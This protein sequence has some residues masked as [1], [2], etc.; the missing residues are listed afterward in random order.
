[1]REGGAAMQKKV[2]VQ[3]SPLAV[4]VP[5][6]VCIVIAVFTDTIA[7]RAGFPGGLSVAIAGVIGLLWLSFFIGRLV[8]QARTVTTERER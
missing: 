7:M 4:T 8:E 5:I 2:R 1:M 6:G 3:L